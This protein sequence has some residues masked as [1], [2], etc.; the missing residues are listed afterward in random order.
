MKRIDPA[1]KKETV[2]IALW[3]VILSTAMQAVFLVIGKWEPS[4]FFAN[5]CSAL[6]SVLNFFLM[7]LTVQN[8]LEKE[9]A[10][11][12]STV[13]GSQIYRNFMVFAVAAAAAYFFHVW[14]AIIPL[15]FPRIA[16]AFRPY[17]D[18]K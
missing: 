13:R 11:A 15:F 10:D 17:F 7:G 8:A 2:Y 14:A 12:K 3:V 18:Q 16:V 5:L 4:V 1:V 6:V 9:E